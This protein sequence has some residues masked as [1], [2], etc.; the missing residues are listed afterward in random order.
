MNGVLAVVR[1][2]ENAVRDAALVGVLMLVCLTVIASAWVYW[3]RLPL[4]LVPTVLGVFG[5]VL[6]LVLI[7]WPRR[8]PCE[9][10]GAANSVTLA[11]SAMAALLLGCVGAGTQPELAWCVV[12]VAAF[13]AGL[14]A[15]DGALARRYH[16]VSAFGARFD[17]EVDAG[18]V[19]ILSVLVLQFDKAGPWVLLAG[20]M[21]Y[22]FVLAGVYLKWLRAELPPSMRRQTV[23]VAQVVTL[24]VCLAPIVPMA[25]SAGLAALALAALVA[26]FVKDVEWLARENRRA[27]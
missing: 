20:L 5:L 18:L 10:F 4:R 6:A 12:G 23:C 3:L 22:L 9:R 24:T 2:R 15:V 8:H 11:R 7:L 25:W 26:S 16:T 1:R 17:M 27:R 19:L 21:R 13:A 14:D